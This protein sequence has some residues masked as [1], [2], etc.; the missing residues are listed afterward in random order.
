MLKK[1]G[2]VLLIL[3][4]SQAIANETG[5][6]L[7]VKMNDALHRMNYSGT[8]VH[9]K[10]SDVNTLHLTHRLKDGVAEEIVNSLN[11]DNQ[12]VSSQTPTFSLVRVPETIERMKAVYA[13]DVGAK[14]K[15][16]MRDCQMLIARPKD[17]MRYLQK[18][19]VDKLTGL[20]L[21]YSLIDNNRRTVERFTFTE[22]SI[23][24]PEA[25]VLSSTTLPPQTYVQSYSREKGNWTIAKLPK[26][27]TFGE[28]PLSQ[29][30]EVKKGT[31]TEHFMLTDGLSSVSIFISP[32]TTAQPKVDSTINSGALNVLTTQKN[33]HRI[34]LVGEIPKSTMQDIFRNLR[35]SGK[36]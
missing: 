13:L 27:F 21:D 15:V 25:E 19:C 2:L 18:Y 36:N 16:A 23:T 5:I 33:N 28:L 26:G 1:M 22:V 17:K 35:Y 14:K 10:G 30:S 11:V 29:E 8:L 34:T 7:L 12:S 6:S 3:S 20:P 32:M 9:I 31:D 4:S 24:R